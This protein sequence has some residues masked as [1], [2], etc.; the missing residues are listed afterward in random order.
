MSFFTLN[1]QSTQTPN[2]FYDEI[3]LGG[4]ATFN[5]VKLIAYILRN[6]LGDHNKA[7]WTS[8]SRKKLVDQAKISSASITSTIE[9]CIE[10]KWILDYKFGSC[11]REERYLFLN[12]IINH[13]IVYFLEKGFV[14]ISQLENLNKKGLDELLERHYLSVVK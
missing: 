12:T 6:N 5:E 9:G 2:V 14:K 7:V 11:G 4:N 10:K 3:L 8:V 13:K 1:K